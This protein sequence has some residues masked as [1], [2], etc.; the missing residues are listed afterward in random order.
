MMNH[1]RMVIADLSADAS[2][3]WW[4]LIWVQMLAD[5]E[6]SLNLKQVFKKTCETRDLVSL[7]V[8]YFLKGI[9]FMSL[10]ILCT[11]WSLYCTFS[12]C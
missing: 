3:E 11:L 10:C 1:F 12:E 2:R 4:L 7:F 8:F 6:A 5:C 9:Y